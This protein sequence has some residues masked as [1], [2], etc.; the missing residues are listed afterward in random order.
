MPWKLAVQTDDVVSRYLIGSSEVR[1][2]WSV[3]SLVILLE[4]RIPTKKLSGS[5]TIEYPGLS[6]LIILVVVTVRV[7]PSLLS[8]CTGNSRTE[9]SSVLRIIGQIRV[10]VFFNGIPTMLVGDAK[11]L[12]SLT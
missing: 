11:D 8:G 10:R 12:I 6:G 4:S 3:E 9:F 2:V 7:I 5:E 1:S